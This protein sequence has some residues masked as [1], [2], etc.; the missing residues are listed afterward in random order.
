MQASETVTFQC[1]SDKTF[2]DNI[3]IYKCIPKFCDNPLKPEDNLN[4][5]FSWDGNLVKIG[6]QFKYNCKDGTALD[7]HTLSKSSADTSISVKCNSSGEFEYPSPFP[8][9]Y[10]K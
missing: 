1:E 6:D 7:D 10:K 5:T 2:S 3:E 4:Y 9:C 8:Q